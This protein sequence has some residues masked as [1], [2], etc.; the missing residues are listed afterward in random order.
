MKQYD[1]VFGVDVSKK[2]VDITHVI[3]QQFTHRQITNNE[4]GMEQLMQFYNRLQLQLPELNPAKVHIFN[5]KNFI[6]HLFQAKY[7]IWSARTAML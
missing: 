2:T 1:H 4:A 3:N 5:L 7:Y 6:Q